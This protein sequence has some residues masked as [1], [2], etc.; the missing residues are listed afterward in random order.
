MSTLRD[1]FIETS[2]LLKNEDEKIK[3]L[4]SSESL[5]KLQEFLENYKKYKDDPLMD[6]LLSRPIPFKKK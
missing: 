4:Q 1:L 5:E 6:Y 2:K 3:E